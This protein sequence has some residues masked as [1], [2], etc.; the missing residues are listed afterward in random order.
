MSSRIL[1]VACIQQ[2]KHHTN[3]MLPMETLCSMS[4]ILVG[5]L[6]RWKR[7][8]GFQADQC[9][10]RPSRSG[11]PS[12]GRWAEAPLGRDEG[13]TCISGWFFQEWMAM[14]T[15]VKL[16][17]FIRWSVEY[18]ENLITHVVPHMWTPPAWGKF[19][20]FQGSFRDSPWFVVRFPLLFEFSQWFGHHHLE[21]IL[22]HRG[23]SFF[24]RGGGC[25]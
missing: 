1:Q 16:I 22:H 2:R 19:P 21:N 15:H 8:H 11:A 24:L 13:L 6:L 7:P 14:E 23:S 5:A 18:P 3:G 10:S 12:G 20:K 25:C 9:N 17:I 4:R